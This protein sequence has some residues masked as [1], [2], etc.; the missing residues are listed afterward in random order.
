MTTRAPAV[1]RP[2]RRAVLALVSI[3][4]ATSDTQILRAQG[5]W[6][7]CRPRQKPPCPHRRACGAPL[8]TSAR[9]HIRLPPRPDLPQL[10]GMGGRKK[11]STRS[12]SSSGSE[13]GD[14]DDENGEPNQWVVA[15]VASMHAAGCSPCRRSA[16]TSA[17]VLATA[18]RSCKVTRRWGVHG[19]RRLFAS[20]ADPTA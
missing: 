10:P 11:T 2:R 14:S 12:S 4:P 19:C 13:S 15:I 16:A 9:A 1:L 20:S 5:A 18:P 8:Q 6:H 7:F 3:N 17:T